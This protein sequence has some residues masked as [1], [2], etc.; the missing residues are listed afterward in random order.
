[1][2]RGRPT[3]LRPALLVVAGLAATLWLAGGTVGAYRYVHRYSLYRGFPPPATPAGVAA[4]T[5]RVIRF[6]SPALRSH[7]EYLVYLP[8]HYRRLAARGRRFPVLYLLHAPPGRPD[9]F[10]KA[11]AMGV[12]EDVGVARH[13][14]RPMLMV[15]PYG[16]TRAYGDDTEWADAGAGPY[17][18]FVLDVVHDV[19]HRF[20]TLRDRQHRAIAGLSE[21]AYGALNVGLH[22][23]ATFSIVQSWS[24][25]F[26]QTPTAAFAGATREQLAANSPAEY[27]PALRPA[28]RRLGL[29]AFLYQG[30]EEEQP[31]ALMTS[32]A[33]QLHAAGAEV[34]YG[35]YPGGHDWGLWR[36]QVP[37]MLRLASRWFG[38]RPRGG[39]RAGLQALGETPAQA[40]RDRERLVRELLRF[41]YAERLPPGVR[42]PN[43]CAKRG[44][45]P[46][47]GR[48][49]HGPIPRALR[50]H[51][52]PARRAAPV[53]SAA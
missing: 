12:R 19:D 52:P 36:R 44:I 31:P 23:L 42:R 51:H 34:G 37:H 24:G 53:R 47:P 13:R 4:G 30:T 41:C 50:R 14:L 5:T 48:R 21:G 1:M 11:G 6:W 32:F 3:P 17:E 10:L 39:Q 49:Y 27:L 29:R 38:Q 45:R 40:R 18:R 46:I 9:G 15:I 33:R 26:V 2:R 7:Q 28:I 8:P 25:Y 20:A 43:I 22:H 35:L 16:K